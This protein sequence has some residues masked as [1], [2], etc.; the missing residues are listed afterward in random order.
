MLVHHMGLLHSSSL[1]MLSLSL[2]VIILYIIDYNESKYARMKTLIVMYCSTCA[3]PEPIEIREVGRWNAIWHNN[4]L[5]LLLMIRLIWLREIARGRGKG[6]LEMRR[7][8]GRRN[9]YGIWEVL[10]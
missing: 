1:R 4:W 5:L 8:V 9:G 2:L 7:I 6:R 10:R 3:H